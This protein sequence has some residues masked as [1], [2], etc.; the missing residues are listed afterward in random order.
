MDDD[1]FLQQSNGE[2]KRN[3]NARA[4]RQLRARERD[5]NCV[6]CTKGS[7]STL[8]M[9]RYW[10]RVECF[11]WRS[12]QALM[13]MIAIIRPKRLE[14]WSSKSLSLRGFF[15]TQ[16]NL[17]A[18]NPSISAVCRDHLLPHRVPRLECMQPL[19]LALYG[20]K[21]VLYTRADNL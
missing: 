14:R 7:E 19:Q 21:I 9:M 8:C 10:V 3:K 4:I 12:S 17:L 18:H 16:I 1:G 20:N 13:T 15:V 2:L 5:L 11:G 6:L